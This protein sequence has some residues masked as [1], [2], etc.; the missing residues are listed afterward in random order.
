MNLLKIEGREPMAR[1]IQSRIRDNIIFL[2]GA[3]LTTLVLSCSAGIP[4][5]S[6]GKRVLENV[7][8]NKGV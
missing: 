1:K 8:K 4:S 7:A 6:D 2:V 3:S 5:E